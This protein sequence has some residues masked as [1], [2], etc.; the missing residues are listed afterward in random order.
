MQ[1]MEAIFGRRSVR[2]YRPDPIPQATITRLIDAAIQAPSA[3]NQQPWSFSVVRDRPL[4][5]RISR[6]AKAH[7]LSVRPHALPAHLYESLGK[8]D[9]HVFYHAPVLIAI[10]A[11]EQGPWIAEDCALAAEN[12]MLAAHGMGLGSC[13]IGLAQAWLD[14]PTGKDALGIPRSHVLIAPIIV[15]I[16]AAAPPTVPRKAPEVHWVG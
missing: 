13:W 8:P 11:I 12:L 15:G 3:V 4:L 5:D 14:T 6:D 10:A 7:M 16:P 9:F 1:V 2:D